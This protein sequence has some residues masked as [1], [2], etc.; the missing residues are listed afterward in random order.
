MCDAPAGDEED[1]KYPGEM[2]GLRITVGETASHHS[3]AA[4]SLKKKPKFHRIPEFLRLEKTFKIEQQ[5]QQGHE[6]VAEN[7]QGF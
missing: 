7:L 6:I 3:L 4:R 5:Q 1:P 2:P